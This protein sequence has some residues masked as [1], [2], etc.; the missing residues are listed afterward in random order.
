MQA[1]KNVVVQ[2]DTTSLIILLNNLLDNAV[3]YSSSSTEII[4]NILQ[5]G[6]T[7]LSISNSGKSIPATELERV[8]DRFYRVPG[9]SATGCGLGLAISKQAAE[10]QNIKLTLVNKT[11]NSGVIARL[12]WN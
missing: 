11:D 6:K 9:S 4:I 1:D 3:R 7:E 8:F 5:N 10:M 12:V 2:T